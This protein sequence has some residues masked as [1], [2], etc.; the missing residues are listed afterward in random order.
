MKRFALFLTPSIA[1]VGA[2]LLTLATSGCGTMVHP[3]SADVSAGL[4]PSD[5]GAP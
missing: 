3:M 5:R 4:I 1:L 2:V